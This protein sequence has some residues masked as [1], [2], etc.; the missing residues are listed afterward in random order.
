MG[1]SKVLLVK[2]ILG[3]HSHLSYSE[4]QQQPPWDNIP[5]PYGILFPMSILYIRSDILITIEIFGA[6]NYLDCLSS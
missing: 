5:L 6:V 1:G 2:L 3:K 4:K